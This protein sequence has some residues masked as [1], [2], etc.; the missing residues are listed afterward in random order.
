[1]D[2]FTLAILPFRKQTKPNDMI[3][4]ECLIEMEEFDSHSEMTYAGDYLQPPEYE[5]RWREWYC[6][7]CGEFKLEEL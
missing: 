6:N 2:A 3:C 4:D 5:V 7:G 1:M